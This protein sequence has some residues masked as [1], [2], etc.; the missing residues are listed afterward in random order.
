MCHT[1]F[2]NINYPLVGLHLVGIK[3][4]DEHFLERSDNTGTPPNLFLVK[5]THKTFAALDLKISTI[6]LL[7]PTRPGWR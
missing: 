7:D 2:E 5:N 6:H 1:R 3:D 4:A